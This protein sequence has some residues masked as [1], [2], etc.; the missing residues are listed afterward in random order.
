M[1]NTGTLFCLIIRESTQL[2]SFRGLKI[3]HNNSDYKQNQS[4]D[5]NS[6]QKSIEQKNKKE[7]NKQTSQNLENKKIPQTEGKIKI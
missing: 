7:L 2:Y 3:I 1:F 4:T 6:I 5:M